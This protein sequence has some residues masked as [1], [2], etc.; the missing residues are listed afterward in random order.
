MPDVVSF[1]GTG[2]VYKNGTA[3]VYADKLG[4]TKKVNPRVEHNVVVSQSGILDSRID[5]KT[6]YSS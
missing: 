2:V 4:N 5:D 3:T 1:A 6:Y